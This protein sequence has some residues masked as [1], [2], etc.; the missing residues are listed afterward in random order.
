MYALMIALVN[1]VISCLVAQFVSRR[2]WAKKFAEYEEVA[3]KM[4]RQLQ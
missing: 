3:A 4:T 1:I 2:Y